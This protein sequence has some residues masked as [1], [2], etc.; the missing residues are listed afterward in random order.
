MVEAARHRRHPRHRGRRHAGTAPQT[1][2]FADA[3]PVSRT[4]GD[5]AFTNAA[6]GGSGSGAITY[7][8]VT[9]A[10]AT[11]DA[12][13]GAVT[14]VSAGTT[15]I[16]AT[17]AADAAHLA[18]QASYTLTV[19]KAQQ[20]IAFNQVGPVAKNFGDAVFTNAASGGSGTGAIS[21]ASADIAVAAVDAASGA[22][23]IVGGGSTQITATKAAD[24]NYL[25]AQA[26]Y[27]LNVSAIAQA[28][29]FPQPGPFAK[30]YGDPPFTNLAGGTGGSGAITYASSDITVLMVNA[31][32]GMVTIVG[33]GGA[34][35]TATRAADSGHSAA[36]ASYQVNVARAPQTIAFA[37]PGPVGKI[38]GDPVFTN[39]ASGGPARAQSP[40]RV[41]TPPSPP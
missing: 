19:A 34:T 36:Q 40:T 35:I 11:V 12:A 41:E 9:P 33:A 14:I 4:F 29:S 7:V 26:S 17:K 16:S 24:T 18:A 6:S 39:T 3:G 30:T 31:A 21:Y 15:S 13:T 22:V 32:T 23:S 2:S 38:Y 27:T 10:V 28:L 1:I 37:Q 8:S 25:A 5:A 20:A